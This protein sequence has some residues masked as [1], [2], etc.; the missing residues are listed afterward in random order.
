MRWKP[1]ILLAIRSLSG[2]GSE[3]FVLTLAQRL[4]DIGCEVHILFLIMIR[5]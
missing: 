2:R 1:K 4:H 3:R 5:I